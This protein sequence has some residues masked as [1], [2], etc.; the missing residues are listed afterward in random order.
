MIKNFKEFTSLNESAKSLEDYVKDAEKILN[1]KLNPFFDSRKE[2]EPDEEFGEFLHLNFGEDMS[3]ATRKTSAKFGLSDPL[4][5]DMEKIAEEVPELSDPPFITIYQDGTFQLWFDAAPYSVS[6][7]TTDQKKEMSMFLTR[8]PLPL[9][10]L[11]RADVIDFLNSIIS[12][13][14]DIDNR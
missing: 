6:Y 7:H 5:P 11:K 8:Y 12:E 1:V 10:K 2:E 9:D 14:R 13:Y 4:F 3:S